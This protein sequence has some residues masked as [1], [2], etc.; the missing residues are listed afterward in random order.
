MND[1]QLESMKDAQVEQWVKNGPSP[2]LLKSTETLGN[3]LQKDGLTT[4]QIRQVFSKLKNIEAKGFA[5]QRTEF[6]ML[7]P[8]I[9]YAAGR[10]QKVKGLQVFKNKISKAIDAVFDGDKEAESVR[11]NNF[12]KLFEAILAYHRAHGGK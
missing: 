9:A 11:F 2:D 7:K 10:Q 4:S 6:M 5:Q 12:C 8:Y 3:E 1:I